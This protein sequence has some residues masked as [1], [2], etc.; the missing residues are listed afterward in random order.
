MTTG[1]TRRHRVDQLIEGV[2]V[3]IEYGMRLLKWFEVD[4]AI[5]FVLLAR[6]WQL[7]AGPISILLITNY[8]TPYAQGFYYTFGSLLALQFFV[9]LGFSLVIINISSHEWA[10]LRLDH[11]GYIVGEP[12]AKSR[13]ISLGRLIYRW[14]AVASVIFILGVSI[15]GYHFFSQTPHPYKNWQTPWI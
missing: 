13:L 6:G 2:R 1:S 14:Y 9:E 11:A 5:F 4:K 12:E 10:H 8:L 15:G 3:S 7:L